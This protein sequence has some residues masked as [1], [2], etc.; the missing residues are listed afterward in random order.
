MSHG[1]IENLS[2]EEALSKLK[3]GNLEYL[4]SKTSSGDVSP[5]KRLDTCENGQH[6]YAVVITCSDSRVI[7][8]SV[9]SAGI[10][11]CSSSAWQETSWTITSWV[12]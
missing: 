8:E 11:S 6:P 4:K 2:A 5:E 1:P 3:N 10:G 9:F 7:P 12:R